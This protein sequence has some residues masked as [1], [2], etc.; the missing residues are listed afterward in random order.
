[1]SNFFQRLSALVENE[2]PVKLI[3]KLPRGYQ[4]IGDIIIIDLMDELIPYSQIIGDKLL[5]TMPYTRTMCVKKG[6]IKG[7]FRIPNVEVIAGDQNTETIHLENHCYFKLDVKKI[8]F[9]K[10]NAS[11]RRR[12]ADLVNDGDIVIDMF[13]GIGYFTINIA[14]HAHPKEIIAV[15]LN[16][17]AFKYLLENIKLNKVQ[18]I[19]KPINANS[20]DI[21]LKLKSV[22]DRII[23]G[24]L[25][26]PKKYIPAALNA[27]K[28][29]G[30]I[31][32]EGIIPAGS[33]PE[34]LLEDFIE[35][36]GL[37]KN[38]FELLNARRIK[39]YGPKKYH[40]RIDVK[41]SK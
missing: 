33:E 6:G 24:L 34:L 1:M 8:M 36:S 41:I 3:P 37:R 40:Y 25:P 7:Q 35:E 16:P 28:N 4:R 2:I 38:N 29:G 12:I 26:S 19:V 14:K 15:E 27:I 21:C 23:M 11:E 32:Y 13:A 31:H 5:K 39:S 20:K 18:K 9:S 22:A 17:I 30:V 10:G